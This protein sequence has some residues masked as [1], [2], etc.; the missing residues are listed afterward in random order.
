MAHDDGHLIATMM[1]IVAVEVSVAQIQRHYARLLVHSAP[2]DARALFHQFAGDMCD[3]DPRDDAVVRAALGAIEVFMMEMGRTLTHADYGFALADLP[4]EHFEALDGG[5]DRRQRV[6]RRLPSVLSIANSEVER[7]RLVAMMTAEQ[8]AGYVTVMAS[9][10]SPRSCNVFAL[11]SSAGCG[12]TVFANA[13]ASSVRATGRIAICVAASALAAMLLLGG[14]TAHSRF[15]IPIPANDGTVCCFSADDRHL[16][17][18]ADV[19]LYDECSMV[20]HDVADTLERSLRD[21]MGDSRPFGGKV[22]VFMGD[23]KQLLPVVRYGRGHEHTMQVCS[24]WREVSHLQFKQNWRAILDPAYAAFLETVGSG[25]LCDVVV[26]DSSRV[27]DVDCLISCVYDDPSTLMRHQILALTLETTSTVN[28]ACLRKW[29]GVLLERFACDTYVDCRDPDGFPHEYIESLSMPGAPPFT[30]GLKIGA[31]YMCI[32]N[33]D[34]AR[35]LANGTMMQ[36]LQI[37]QRCLQFRLTSGSNAGAVELLIPVVFHITS[38]ASGLPFAVERRQFPVIPAFCLSVHKAQ[39]QSLDFVGLI[40]ES[41]P[42]AHGQLYVALSRAGSW[43]KIRVLLS[44]S[45][46]ALKNLV[47]QHLIP[48]D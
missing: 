46:V 16:I 43:A 41:D 18:S 23:F 22:V 33:I 6:R 29:P 42:F 11:L 12:K 2:Q 36:L 28:T 9:I 30:L 31:K 32:R 35:G 17:R 13:V 44:A 5:G 15:H 40:F 3:G 45:A 34:V 26:P 4:D 48:C 38:E 47:Y 8:R 1:E 20:H 39:G 24:W 10:G 21:L 14:T 19:I 7:D 25:T 27:P 37:D